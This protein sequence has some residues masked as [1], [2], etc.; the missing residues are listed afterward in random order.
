M[1]VLAVLFI[2]SLGVNVYF[3]QSQS[4]LKTK[5][6]DQEF[7]I[8][9]YTNRLQKLKNTHS[10][11]LNTF[12]KSRNNEMGADKKKLEKSSATSK[13][14]KPNI[15]DDESEIQDVEQVGQD[16]LY[17]EIEEEAKELEDKYNNQA[18]RFFE[19]ELN[20][21]EKNYREYQNFVKKY[22]DVTGEVYEEIHKRN[23]QMFGDKMP[24]GQEVPFVMSY[25]DE[26]KINAVRDNIINELEQRYGKD[27]VKR[28]MEFEREM[29][30]KM[31]MENGYYNT[32]GIF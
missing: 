5:I 19:S 28:L 18:I 22:E 3:F 7:L 30:V 16:Y 24:N 4:D 29:K 8:S 14:D 23:S 25:E 10:Q 31:I 13:N 6:K 20:L 17:S 21:S 15:D 1:K 32:M 11:K 9:E 12:R 27:K 2:L 26:R